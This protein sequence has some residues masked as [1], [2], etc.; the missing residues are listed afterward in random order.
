MAVDKNQA[1]IDF[2]MNCPQIRD[3]P[4]Y[5]NFTEAEDN[6]KGIITVST[7]NNLDKR[8]IDGSI[9]KRFTFSIIDFKSVV[10]QALPVS[11][12]LSSENVEDMF[13]VQAIIDWI[14]EQVENRNFPDFGEK[15]VVDSM[16]TTTETPNLNGVDTNTKPHL[17][18]YGI[19]ILIDYLDTSKCIWS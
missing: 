7:D 18:K 5:F 4:T 3:N 9:M 14:Q 10:Y 15:S 1:I 2:L 17:A 11:P 16:K 12:G 19:S 6:N 13:E 8:F